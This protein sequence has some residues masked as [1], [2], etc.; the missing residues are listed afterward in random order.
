MIRKGPRPWV[1]RGAGREGVVGRLASGP[2]SEGRKVFGSKVDRYLARLITRDG[3]ERLRVAGNPE[4]GQIRDRLGP[5]GKPCM[6]DDRGQSGKS[7]YEPEAD[8][9]SGCG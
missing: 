3:S 2:W 4:L 9:E 7:D 8:E 6:R 1:L 5:D